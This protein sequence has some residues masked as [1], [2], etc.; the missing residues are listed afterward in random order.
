[1]KLTNKQIQNILTG[2]GRLS[3]DIKAGK[4]RLEV[5]TSFSVAIAKKKLVPIYE[6][7]DESR[8]SLRDELVQK[9]ESGQPKKIPEKT[10]SEGNVLIPEQWDLGMNLSKWE[11]GVKDLLL[12]VVDVERLEPMKLEDFKIKPVK[13]KDGKSEEPGDIDPDI[14]FLLTPWLVME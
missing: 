2:M 3:E 4:L 8:T 10:D 6:A 11:Q 12:T 9:D 1:M 14:L 13:S 7:M 5:G